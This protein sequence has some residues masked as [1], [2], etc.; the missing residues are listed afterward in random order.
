MAHDYRVL[1][2]R[3]GEEA[4]ELCREHGEAIDL[5]LTD[6]VMPAMA[7]AELAARA[8]ELIPSLRV[9]YM[10]G[11]IDDEHVRPGTNPP[12]P[13]LLQKPFGRD[14]LLR[15]VARALDP[16]SPADPAHPS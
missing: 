11:Y 7:G 16:S 6:S 1:S 8:L 14:A 13:A 15:H 4:L 10:S 5:L 3:H 12:A 2:A 9:L